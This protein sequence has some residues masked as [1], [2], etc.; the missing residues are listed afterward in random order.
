MSS[1]DI[2]SMT[3]DA[4]RTVSLAT[5]VAAYPTIKELCEKI[6]RI[7]PKLQINVYKIT[8]NFFGE[9]ITVAGLL[10]GEDIKE[11]LSGKLLGEEL[12][13][14]ESALRHGEEVFLCGMTVPILSAALG[15]KV[16]PVSDGCDLFIKLL[17]QE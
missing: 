5:G 2:A 14:P 1:P 3:L 10:T 12:L 4:P 8:N 15:V 17:G 13:I 11:Q 16:T 9:T 6:E 7:F